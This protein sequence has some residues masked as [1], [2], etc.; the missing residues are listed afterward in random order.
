MSHKTEVHPKDLEKIRRLI[1]Q[2]AKDSGGLKK[3]SCQLGVSDSNIRN[4]IA[5]RRAPWPKLL[6]NFGY[7]PIVRY[8]RITK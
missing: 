3:L 2:A 1:K 7:K 6:S 5:G 4:V 8:V